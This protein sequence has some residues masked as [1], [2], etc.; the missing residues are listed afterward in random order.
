MPIKEKKVPV[1]NNW[2][3]KDR[4]Y[5]LVSRKQP[6]VMTLA[7]RHTEKRPLLWF[8]EEKGYQRELRYATN[9]RSCFADEQEGPAT[10]AHIIFR[11]GTLF[12]PK[13]EQALQKLL[14]LYHP[15]REALYS[16]F[17]AVK[18]AVDEL[19]DIEIELQ[20]L[21]LAAS[22]EID[23]AEAILRVEYGSRVN[24]MTSKELK[25]DIMVFAKRNP[26]LLIELANDENVQ[27]RNFGIKAVEAGVL[28]LADDQRTFNWATNGRKVITVPFDE[29][30][31]SALASFFKTDDGIEIYQNIEKRLK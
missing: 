31:Y 30:P 13:Q 27:I 25:R 10:L 28:K 1:T 11:D 16:E 21:N 9:M 3:M 26:I 24:E 14:S 2:E 5:Y 29:N 8:D 23:N 17:D 15:L 12:V 7:S 6:I 4:V 22:M 20:A 19:G 18:E